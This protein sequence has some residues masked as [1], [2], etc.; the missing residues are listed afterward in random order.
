MHPGENQPPVPHASTWFPQ[1]KS[2]ESA[3][4][5]RR[6]N[7]TTDNTNNTG[8]DED[9]EDDDEIE[10]VGSS[11]NLKCPLSMQVSSFPSDFVIRQSRISELISFREGIVIHV[12]VSELRYSTPQLLSLRTLEVGY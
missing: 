12:F 11:S 9:D 2:N 5:R 4:A 6:R 1:D 8:E 10:M 7:N 3:G